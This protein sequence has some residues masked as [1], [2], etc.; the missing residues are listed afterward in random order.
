MC[1]EVKA[2]GSTLLSIKERKDTKALSNL[3]ARQDTVIQG[4]TTDLRSIA[5]K[6]AESSIDALLE[7]RK[8][9]VAR[10]EYYLALTGTDDKSTPDENQE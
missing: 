7:T 9:Q 2:I 6:E 5:K 3:R 4:L 10:L 8:A 1:A